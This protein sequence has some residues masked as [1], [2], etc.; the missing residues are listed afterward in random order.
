MFETV[1]AY[2]KQ[3][4]QELRGYDPA[5]IQDALSDAEEFLRT[6]LMS[7]KNESPDISEKD[8]LGTIIDK[9]DLQVGI[10][11]QHA[12]IRASCN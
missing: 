2:L 7:A 9:Y 11:L 8:A 5:L 12:R 6:A 10:V 1:D 4:K 3:L